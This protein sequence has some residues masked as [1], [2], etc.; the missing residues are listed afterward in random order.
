MYYQYCTGYI[1]ISVELTRMDEDGLS[2]PVCENTN[3]S[4][5]ISDDAPEASPNPDSVQEELVL[6]SLEDTLSKEREKTPSEVSSPRQLDLSSG[7]EFVSPLGSNSNSNLHELELEPQVELQETVDSPEQVIDLAQRADSPLPEHPSSSDDSIYS[8]AIDP[9]S[10]SE[11]ASHVEKRSLRGTGEHSTD[12][13]REQLVWAKVSGFRFWPGLIVDATCAT[14]LPSKLRTPFREGWL[15]IHFFGTYDYAWVPPKSCIV[16]WYLGNKKGYMN[17]CKSKFF[18]LAV[19]EANRFKTEGSE[20]AGFSAIPQVLES[21]S[22]SDSPVIVEA[23]AAKTRPQ[24]RKPSGKN[25]AVINIKKI[26]LSNC[27]S[28]SSSQEAAVS[29]QDKPRSKRR[30]R[31]E[32]VMKRMGLAAPD[33]LLGRKLPRKVDTEP[34]I[35]L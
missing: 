11:Q 1:G 27:P 3:V 24:K 9:S 31:C 4:D 23:P 35:E 33:P 28:S 5:Y 29:E 32:L 22:D 30:R 2:L 8:P 20:P 12:I 10:S 13:S 14:N 25:L 26:K 16:S 18:Q 6:A 15:L 34:D 19:S 7:E 21:G 17:K